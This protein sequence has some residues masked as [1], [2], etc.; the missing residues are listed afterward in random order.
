VNARQHEQQRPG[1]PRSRSAQRGEAVIGGA[2]TGVPS[3][4][5][6]VEPITWEQF[7]VQDQPGSD[8]RLWRAAAVVQVRGLEW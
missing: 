2:R 8:H 5:L 1:D 4:D 7:G 6:L 3:V